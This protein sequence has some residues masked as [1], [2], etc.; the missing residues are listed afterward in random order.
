MGQG[1]SFPPCSTP[2]S[3]QSLS[4]PRKRLTAA[5][6]TTDT[7]EKTSQGDSDGTAEDRGERVL[8]LGRGGRRHHLPR[9]AGAGAL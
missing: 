5:T 1:S 2:C 4:D 6:A 7:S 8:H 9:H 3:A